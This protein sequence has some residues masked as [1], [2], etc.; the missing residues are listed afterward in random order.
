MMRWAALLKGVNLNE[1]KLPMA[2]LKALVEWLGYR[3][4]TTLLASGNVVF[5]C[6][7]TD[8]AKVEAAIEAA[9]DAYG[10]N[11]DVVVRSAADLQAILA[12]NP[13][14]EAALARPNHVVV[15]FHRDSVPADRLDA[16]PQI[17][18]GRETL[19]ARGRELY[20]DYIDGIGASKLPQAMA[21]LKFPR[22]A[23]ARNWNT[24]VKL[25]TL[26]ED[27]HS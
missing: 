23:T 12:A 25:A 15:L 19:I 8:G 18:Q 20:V 2:D 11:T 1:R 13:F 3:D 5:A 22:I 26:L 7:E 27:A 4:V 10:L 14:P 9:L 6:D 21:K 24:V 16:L 17:Y